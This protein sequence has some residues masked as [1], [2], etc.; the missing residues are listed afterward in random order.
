MARLVQLAGWRRLAITAVCLATWRLLDQIPVM[1]FNPP[2]LALR[3]HE[4]GPPGVLGAIADSIPVAAYSIG[5]LG[6]AP[7]IDAVI[8]VLLFQVI[9]KPVRA[10]AGTGEGRVRLRRWTRALAV[11]LALASAYGWVTLLQSENALAP[12]LDKFSI[13][14]VMLELTG[15]AVIV[16][17]LAEVLDEYGI[18]FG[19]GAFLIYALG[20]VATQTYR[21]AALFASAPSVEALY[22]PMGIWLGFSITVA[23]GA[24]AILLAVRRVNP[25]EEDGKPMKRLELRLV[26]SGVLLPVLFA[27]S[28]MFLPPM[29]G[30][31]YPG[32][33]RW[34][35]DHWTAL[36]P[37]P[38]T[39]AAYVAT[40]AVLIAF[41]AA[42]VTAAFVARESI[43]LEVVAHIWLLTLIGGTA[44][45][46]LVAVLPVLEEVSSR[47]AGRLMPM[48]GLNTVLVV[49]L[50]V[51]IVTRLEHPKRRLSAMEAMLQPP[52]P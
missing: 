3:S 15:G 29:V 17:L 11:A 45:A 43:Q 25:P 50:V 49:A 40:Y 18:G 28:V 34:I 37:N 1:G 47:A 30:M 5:L 13:L 21:L 31:Y 10:L 6:I 35:S 2:Y 22:A 48:S 36:G 51:A 27:Q 23:G 42:F 19:Y 44:L 39:D 26:M 24:A 33:T 9:S 8:V 32:A 41:F 20:P 38:W 14:V 46:L 4:L 52:A 12:N 7:Y 16:M